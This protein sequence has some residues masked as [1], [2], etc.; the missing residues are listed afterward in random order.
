MKDV[1]GVAF[2]DFFDVLLGDL[3]DGFACLLIADGHEDTIGDDTSL[4]R[5]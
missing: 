5:E 3:E 4:R 1:L 2:D